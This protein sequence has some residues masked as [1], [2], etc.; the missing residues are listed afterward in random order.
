MVERFVAVGR[1][2]ANDRVGQGGVERRAAL[3]AAVQRRARLTDDSF[4]VRRV[5][6]N[7]DDDRAALATLVAFGG[8]RRKSDFGEHRLKER[9]NEGLDLRASRVGRE[10]LMNEI[11]LA[12]NLREHAA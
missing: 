7:S 8:R 6:Q 12:H 11:E 10:V 2:D 5:A 4:V 9:S 3:Q 1:R